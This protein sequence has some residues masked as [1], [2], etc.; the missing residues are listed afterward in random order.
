MPQR[1]SD[2]DT[3]VVIKT[4]FTV[5]LVKLTATADRWRF[6]TLEEAD[7]HIEFLKDKLAIEVAKQ[8]FGL[9]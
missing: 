7:K 9:N 5:D 3:R 1:T 6:A 8:A 4:G 2:G